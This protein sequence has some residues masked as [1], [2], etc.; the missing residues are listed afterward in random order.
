MEKNAKE[1]PKTDSEIKKIND[2]EIILFSEGNDKTGP[3]LSESS[4]SNAEEMLTFDEYYLE[5]ARFGELKDLKEA[6]K[7]ADKS[8][9]V[10]IKDFRGNTALHMACAN[11]HTEMVKYLINTLHADINIRNSS[12][13]TPLG[14]AAL[15]G[16]KEIVKILLDNNA[17]YDNKNSQGKTPSEIA[18]DTGNYEIA[19]MIVQKELENKKDLGIKEEDV[20]GQEDIIDEEIEDQK[21]KEIKK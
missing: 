17:D 11:G 20:T 21:N 6:M 3:E 16:Q 8:F 19:E 14:W 1:T 9:N 13:N 15:N 18:Y 5:C 4:V 12:N 7:E 10:N 2:D